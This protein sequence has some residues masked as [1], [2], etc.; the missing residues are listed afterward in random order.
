MKRLHLR[1]AAAL[2]V[3]ALVGVGYQTAFGSETGSSRQAPASASAAAPAAASSMRVAYY[4]TSLSAELTDVTALSQDEGWAVGT[5]QNDDGTGDPKPV[6]LH[7]T[8]G[9]WAQSPLPEGAEK[10]ALTQIEGSS[11]DNVWLFGRSTAGENKPVAFRWDGKTW[12]S[13]KAPASDN[14]WGGQR[15]AA[16]LA[17]DDVWLL[18]GEKKAHHWDG[19]KWSTSQLPQ[20][21]TSVSGTGSGDVWAVGYRDTDDSGGGPM[22]QPAAMHWDG[23][24]WKTTETPEYRF[25]DPGP[26]EETASLDSVVTVSGKEVWAVG[27]HTF[28]HGEGGPEPEEENILL[29]WDGEKWAKAPAKATE[30]AS[31]E[32][33][34]DGDGGLVLGRYWHMTKD[35]TLHEIARHK[36]VPGRSGKVEEVDKKQRFWPSETVLVPGTRQVWSA[37]VIELGAYGDANFRRAGVLSYDAG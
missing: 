24:E 13:V 36:P 28:N 27:T 1:A 10:A 19:K 30:K 18:G 11:P 34:S 25:P 20:N 8:D 6:L 3:A 29:R 21:A 4:S 37:G 26:P 32:T 2:A 33:A 35:G 31:L 23:T 15:S 5:S 16:V 12:Q 7:R 9:K 14:A 17:A 22:S